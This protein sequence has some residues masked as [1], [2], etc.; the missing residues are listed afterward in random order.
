MY[1]ALKNWNENIVAREGIPNGFD[2]FDWD[3]EGANEP[4]SPNNFLTPEVITLVGE[5]S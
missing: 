3:L 1:A 5:I 2:G 4:S